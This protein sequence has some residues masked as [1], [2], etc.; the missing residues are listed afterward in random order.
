MFPTM[1][2]RPP[3]DHDTAD[4]APAPRSVEQAPERLDVT[5]D[6]CIALSPRRQRAV[7]TFPFLA[8]LI[9]NEDGGQD[10]RRA[11]SVAF[12]LMLA[13]HC[14]GL[15]DAVDHGRPL[16]PVLAEMLG[17]EPW[18]VNHVQRHWS[19]FKE[20]DGRYGHQ[21]WD[22]GKL[23][24]NWTPET[25]PCRLIPLQRLCSLFRYAAYPFPG[26]SG[27]SFFDLPKHA[28]NAHDR[29]TLL[30]IIEDETRYAALCEYLDFLSS[31]TS[32]LSPRLGKSVHGILP[33]LVGA[34]AIADWWILCLRWH[35]IN[36][37]LR[38]ERAI[39]LPNDA[40][41]P[42]ALGL[43]T[44]PVH[45]GL[46]SFHNLRNPLYRPRVWENDDSYRGPCHSPTPRFPPGV[47]YVE[48]DGIHHATLNVAIE[49]TANA[50]TIRVRSSATR[51]GW[52]TLDVDT[53]TAVDQFVGSFNAGE[54][55]LNQQ[56]VAFY[57]SRAALR[58]SLLEK[59]R[60]IDYP[61]WIRLFAEDDY[62][63]AHTGA[64]GAAVFDAYR[65]SLALVATADEGLFHLAMEAVQRVGEPDFEFIK[66]MTEDA[67]KQ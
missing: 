3:D 11:N 15:W 7:D 2:H 44:E 20:V 46:Y 54:I 6:P 37:D 67:D 58:A 19:V 24:V 8:G 12:Q 33:R 14:D 23:L 66:T 18:M 21:V 34:T 61:T 22:I 42:R 30:A 9:L 27:R 39:N 63:D 31:L 25:A 57:L 4:E 55:L 40:P 10:A 47:V 59:F 43:L 28:L 53:Q 49:G 26:T 51:I 5:S 52:P 48:L 62:F 13:K 17:W 38:R 41:E 65:E 16:M 60:R 64:S 36:E 32:W 45:K 1:S 29:C 35:R 50:P 56:T